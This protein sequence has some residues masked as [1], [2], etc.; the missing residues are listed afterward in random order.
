MFE[1]FG[2]LKLVQLTIGIEIILVVRMI[3]YAKPVL[4][5]AKLHENDVSMKE[6]LKSKSFQNTFSV[7]QKWQQP[8]AI[9]ISNQ[10][11][12]DLMLNWLC[13]TNVRQQIT[14]KSNLNI[15]EN[16]RLSLS[17]GTRFIG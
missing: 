14:P 13:N 15:I 10:Y 9:F 1:R 12:C 16:E 11:A 3:Y 17:C 6:I 4:N 2:L 7:V 5:A 8:P